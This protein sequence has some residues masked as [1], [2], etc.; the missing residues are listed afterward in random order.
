MKIIENE[1]IKL[2]TIIIAEICIHDKVCSVK[3][4]IKHNDIIKKFKK[5][6]IDGAFNYN[7]LDNIIKD[8]QKQVRKDDIDYR[9]LD[10]LT[11][12]RGYLKDPSKDKWTKVIGLY[13]EIKKKAAEVL[14]SVNKLN[15]NSL[16]N[17]VKILRAIVK[18]YEPN[19]NENFNFVLSLKDAK[20]MQ[21]KE[22]DLYSK[23]STI[24]NQL[25]S[26]AKTFIQQT[27]LKTGSHMLPTTEIAERMKAVGLPPLFH[28]QVSK[29]IYLDLNFNLYAFK[30]IKLNCKLAIYRVMIQYNKSYNKEDDNAYILKYMVIGGATWQFCYS[31]RYKKQATKHKFSAVYDAIAKLEPARKIWLKDLNSN[32]ITKA[33]YGAAVEIVYHTGMRIGT[34]GNETNGEPT[35]GLL[36]ILAK[37]VKCLNNGVTFD[38]VGKA[39]VKHVHTI[40]DKKVMKIVCALKSKRK[41]NERLFSITPEQINLYVRNRL[42]LPITI[43]KF[44]TIKGTKLA[45]DKLISSQPCKNMKSDTEKLKYLQQVLLDVGKELGHYSGNKITGETALKNYIDPNIIKQY[46]E[47]CNLKMNKKIQQIVSLDEGMDNIPDTYPAWPGLYDNTP[48]KGKLTHY[49][50]YF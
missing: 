5:I 46:F 19:A 12:I 1:L 7:N 35:Y 29:D 20:K 18:K 11:A 14:G 21:E 10:C 24:F 43:H 6:K 34:K 4:K 30:T 22:P 40:H 49:T 28:D 3:E 15:S 17:D 2:E 37:D 9:I 47:T 48:I 27:I 50:K 25:V 41:D 23:Y 8:V 38:Y 31:E 26:Q 44:R 39:G 36:T 33:Q 16:S 13:S 45:Y 42:K 32:D